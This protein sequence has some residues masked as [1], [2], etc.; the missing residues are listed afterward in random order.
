MKVLKFG[1]TSVGSVSSI[2]SLKQI[3]EKEAKHQSIIVVVSALGGITDQLIKTSLLAREGDE[4]WRKEFDAMVDRHHKMIDT[5]ITDTSERELLFNKVDTLFEQLQSIY[6]GVF[7]IHDLSHKTQDTIESYGERLS[8][9]I[10]ASLIR[11]SKWMDARK[12]IKTEKEHG[13]QR[14]DT[15]LTNQLVK[16]TFKSLPRISIVPGFIAEDRDTGDITNLGRGGSDYTASILAAA[17]D[18]EVLEIWTDVD[19]FMTADPRVIKEAY[20][21]N[22]LS[23]AEAMELSNFG[24]KVIYP[25]TIYPVCVKNIPIRVKNTFN[26]QGKGTI[27][28]SSIENNQKPIKGISSIKATTVITV[29]GLSMVGVVG[30]NRRIFSSLAANGIS[31]FLV[32]QAAS[33]NNTSIGVKDED[34]VNA[35]NVLN[36]E[37]KL[38]IEDGRMFPMYAE[39]GLATVAIVGENMKH[40]PGITGKLFGTLG[41]SGISIIAIAQGASEM[42]I[43]FVVKGSDL[44]KSLNVL[45]DS[46]FLSEYKVLNLFICGVGTV[47]GKLIEQI[48]KQYEEL[49]LH[50]NL[51]LNVVGIASSR[52]AIFNREGLDL[53]HYSEELKASEPSNPEKLRDSILQMNIF[54]SVFVDCTASKDVADLYQSLLENNISVV[55]ANKIAASGSFEEYELLKRTALQR[56][57]KFRFETNVGA[58]LPIIGTINDLR[59]SG[60]K[61]L[62]IEA[63]LSGTLNFIFNE[64]N[65]DVPFSETVKRAKE[66]GYSEPDPRIDLSGKDVIRKLVILTREAGYKVNQEDVEKNLFVPDEFFKGSLEDFW[67]NLPNLDTD[68]EQRRQRLSEEGKRWRFVATM[69]NGRTSV[70]LKEVAANHPFYNLE[71]SNNI[72]LLT[73]ERYKEYP[74]QIQGYGAGASVTA[75][76]VFANIMSIANI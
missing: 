16:D 23:Y 68:F 5:I 30:V 66:Q 52:N 44:R 58:G 34:A 70:A 75:A 54:N 62:K 71:G 15:E 7:L 55:A 43:S 46:F 69:D 37:F 64:I 2:L 51:K 12:F 76:G 36:E 53:D 4:S 14:L 8:S 39:S 59:N 47:G 45:H 20:T 31:V 25:P 18:A 33:E 57:V 24:A 26:P 38:E 35:V 49:K 67:K 27:I 28:K 56:G 48:K 63:V 21:I 42:N 50:S 61:I 1:G 60:D 6:Y 9:N 41:R 3:V 40:S 22:E 29:T 11:G 32:S 17:L 19:G 73:T 74:M 10:V 72:V 65:A 13:R